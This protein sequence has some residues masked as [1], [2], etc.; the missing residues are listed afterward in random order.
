[1]SS[2]S[3]MHSAENPVVFRKQLTPIPQ[4]SSE[5]AD[6][7]DPA[8]T[9][10]F[11][12]RPIPSQSLE[13]LHHAFLANPR[14]GVSAHVAAL[15]ATSRATPIAGVGHQASPMRETVVTVLLM[16]GSLA[17]VVGVVGPV[18][19]EGL[20]GP[21]HSEPS[22]YA[23]RYSPRDDPISN[24]KRACGNVPWHLEATG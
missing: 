12:H 8:A 3:S 6:E 16:G 19:V 4:R 18:C 23:K 24:A 22:A 15:W 11:W 9:L 13:R 10:D 7:P 21:L 20:K 17:S 1:M 14:M 5:R 2:K